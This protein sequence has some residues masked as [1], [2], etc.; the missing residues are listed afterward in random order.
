MGANYLHEKASIEETNNLTVLDSILIRCVKKSRSHLFA[1]SK[2]FEA[3]KKEKIL[4]GFKQTLVHGQ[5]IATNSIKTSSG[6]SCLKPFQSNIKY[7]I[8]LIKKLNDVSPGTKYKI[9][10]RLSYDYS[11]LIHSLIN[12]YYLS[13]IRSS[14]LSHYLTEIV[15]ALLCCVHNNYVFSSISRESVD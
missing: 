13:V 14:N 15:E 5:K 12:K 8:G 1:V 9:Y 6:N 10:E 11:C 4:I 7:S 3:K 2:S